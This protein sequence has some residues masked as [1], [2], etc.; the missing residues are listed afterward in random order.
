VRW[1]SRGRD[2]EISFGVASGEFI[3]AGGAQEVPRRRAPLRAVH[4]AG[5]PCSTTSRSA[6][7]GLVTRIRFAAKQRRQRRQDHRRVVLAR[8]RIEGVRPLRLDAVVAQ[9]GPPSS[10]R[11]HSPGRHLPAAAGPHHLGDMPP[12]STLSRI[13]LILMV[14]AAVIQIGVLVLR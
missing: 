10:P 13:V 8:H 1:C 11:Q 9:A 6:P 12:I 4:G 5:A 7:A 14:V 2:V 3:G